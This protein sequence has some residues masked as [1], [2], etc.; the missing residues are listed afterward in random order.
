MQKILVSRLQGSFNTLVQ[1]ILNGLN[2]GIN[3]T[4]SNTGNVNFAVKYDNTTIGINGSNQLYV[5]SSSGITYHKEVFTA[6]AGQ[7][8]FT[9]T[10]TP[11][12]NSERVSL[13][14]QEMI[15]SLSNDYTISTNTVTFNYPLLLGDEIMI[16]YS[17]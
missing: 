11:I 17:T 10:F 1:N 15:P 12:T 2:I 14:G 6:T 5:K 8:V 7:T 13:N 9:L 4:Q 16:D 3:V